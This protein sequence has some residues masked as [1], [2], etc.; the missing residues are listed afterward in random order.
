MDLP[1]TYKQFAASSSRHNDVEA[2]CEKIHAWAQSKRW[3]PFTREDRLCALQVKDLHT[4]GSH[5]GYDPFYYLVMEKLV[6]VGTEVSE[7]IEEWRRGKPLLYEVESTGD[8]GV[9]EPTNKPEGVLVELADV[10]I[11]VFDL[12]HALDPDIDFGAVIAWKMAYNEKRPE[13]HGG[14]RG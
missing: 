1:D 6:L 12:V 11:R 3:W 4:D 9:M 2:W 13:R 10:V 8:R 14:L 7:A 5:C